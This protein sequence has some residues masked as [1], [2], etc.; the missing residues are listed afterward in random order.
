M[1]SERILESNAI[2][3][4][5]KMLDEELLRYENEVVVERLS[6]PYSIRVE[7]RFINE[8]VA[9]VDYYIKGS[10]AGKELPERFF[11][12]CFVSFP[13]YVDLIR[14]AGYTYIENL[15]SVLSYL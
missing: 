11:A 1:S 4:V 13:Y 2:E 14:G 12:K 9:S 10:H 5:R 6:A 15:E 3:I 7:A 8:T